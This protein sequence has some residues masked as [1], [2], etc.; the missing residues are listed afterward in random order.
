M[1]FVFHWKEFL[2][3]AE[4]WIAKS[5]TDV[6]STACPIFYQ[7]QKYISNLNSWWK[8]V[9]SLQSDTRFKHGGCYTIKQA[10]PQKMSLPISFVVQRYPI[11]SMIQRAIIWFV[12]TVRNENIPHSDLWEELFYCSNVLYCRFPSG[13]FFSDN[14]LVLE[15]LFILWADVALGR[16]FKTILKC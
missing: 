3:L 1:H 8:C 4:Y 7:L 2:F 14:Y 15:C 10:E 11:E 13:W 6:Y 9:K 5:C 12:L 16:L